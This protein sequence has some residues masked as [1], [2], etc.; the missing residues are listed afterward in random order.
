MNLPFCC[1]YNMQL[2][3]YFYALGPQPSVTQRAQ[4][5][6][7]QVFEIR[8]VS[9]DPNAIKSWGRAGKPSVSAEGW[10][11]ALALEGAF[12]PRAPQLRASLLLQNGSWASALHRPPQS[13][14]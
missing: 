12:Q 5:V 10:A 14:G 9:E 7:C 4:A 13:Q 11:Q 1:V 8:F 2:L 6:S 3:T